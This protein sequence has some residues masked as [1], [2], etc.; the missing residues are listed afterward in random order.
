MPTFRLFAAAVEPKAGLAVAY[1]TEHLDD[2]SDRLRKQ[3]AGPAEHRLSALEIEL[4]NYMAG[5]TQKSK[6]VRLWAYLRL[7]ILQLDRTTFA[8]RPHRSRIVRLDSV[9]VG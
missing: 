7:S 5:S 3:T 9:I 2:I 1:K 4:D 8:E 6:D